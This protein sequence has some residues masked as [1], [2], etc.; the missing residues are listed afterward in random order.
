[1][2][3]TQP[4]PSSHPQNLPQK[5]GSAVKNF[6]VV[7]LLIAL[8]IVSVPIGMFL[9]Q[10]NSSSGDPLNTAHSTTASAETTSQED[11]YSQGS[12]VQSTHN[13]QDTS[14]E[15]SDT[16]KTSS[17]VLS[18][19]VS[20]H[21]ITVTETATATPQVP[22]STV[23]ETTAVVTTSTATNESYSGVSSLS[24]YDEPQCDGRTILIVESVVITSSTANEVNAVQTALN[25][26][27]GAKTTRP[28]ACPS[29][30]A[31]KPDSQGRSLSDPNSDGG[32]IFPIY[33]DYGSDT[34]AACSAAGQYPGS[35]PRK[36]SN[37]QGDYSSPC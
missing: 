15:N 21:V 7:A 18:A 22:T 20:S 17:E 14:V 26:H 10:K 34:A 29:L 3:E 1:M 27:P 35:N 11:T 12:A 25:R 9:F 19:E 28:G 5:K 4:Y 16:N 33:Y 2:N 37:T 8:F 13:A 23:K 31:T 32:T 6:A 24:A 36:L 30:R